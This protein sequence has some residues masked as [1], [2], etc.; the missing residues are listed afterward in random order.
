ML[1][2]SDIPN[3]HRLCRACDA[4]FAHST[5]YSPRARE[6]AILTWMQRMGARLGAIAL[7]AMLVRAIVP[8]GYMLAEADAGN[9]RYLTVQMCE[10]HAATVIDLD[11]GKQVDPS[12]LPEKTDGKGN[13]AP[14]VFAAAVSVATHVVTAEQVAFVTTQDVDFAIVRDLRPGRGIAAPPPATGPPAHA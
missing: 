4:F 7:L 2:W 10:G 11:T 1:P 13:H 6:A 14:C 12:Q 8:A 5:D 3:L 9:G